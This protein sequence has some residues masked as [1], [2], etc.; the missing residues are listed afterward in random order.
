MPDKD[1]FEGFGE[2]IEESEENVDSEETDTSRKETTDS[3]QQSTEQ[4]D[5]DAPVTRIRDIGQTTA[6]KLSEAGVETVGD[7]RETDPETVAEVAD[8]SQE[9]AELLVTRAEASPVKS[10]AFPDEETMQIGLH[11]REETWKEVS[12]DLGESLDVALDEHDVRGVYAREKHDAVLRV[13]ANH[14]DEV[15]RQIISARE[16]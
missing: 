10:P 4:I 11:V 7:L 3:G 1:A 6:E 15:I 12:E 14:T 9:K 8:R 5:G 13:A 2:A 16:T